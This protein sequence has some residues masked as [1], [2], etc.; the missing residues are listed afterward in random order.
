MSG[1]QDSLRETM[2]VFE[3]LKEHEAN[4]RTA[5]QWCVEALVAEHKIL[6][7]GNGG[8]AAEAQHLAAELMGR[9]KESRRPLAAVALSTDTA[10]LT[11]VSN[12]FGY[13]E[14]FARQVRGLARAGDVVIVF[15]TSGNSPNVLAALQAARQKGIRS[16]AFLGSDGGQAKSLA[17]CALIV[18]HRDSARAQEGHQFLMHCLMDQIETGVAMAELKEVELL[19]RLYNDFNARDVESVLAALHEDVIWANGMEGG[20]VH[21]RDGVRNYWRRQW[22]MVDPRV[23]PVEFSTGAEGEVMVEVHQV[24]HDPNGALLADRMVGHVFRIEGGLVKRF[25]I[26][27]A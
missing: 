11:C 21:G 20:H 12:D 22:T 1:F 5:A 9:Y 23:D 27:G 26:R 14:V 16:I 4:L 17:D 15:T 19:K 3:G 24:V 10:V 6:I 18:R 2:A 13:E 25:D 8:S 7:C